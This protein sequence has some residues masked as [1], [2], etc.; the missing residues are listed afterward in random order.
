MNNA[1]GD[2]FDIALRWIERFAIVTAT[3]T[4]AVTGLMSIG[5]VRTCGMFGFEL[6]AFMV[7]L[8]GGSFLPASGLWWHRLRRRA[9]IFGEAGGSRLSCRLAFFRPLAW[10]RI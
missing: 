5:A 4:F 8:S 6:G 1:L 9:R 10:S 3:I 2:P 7:A